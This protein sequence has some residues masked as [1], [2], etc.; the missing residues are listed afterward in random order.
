MEPTK[1]ELREE[2]RAIK[3]AGNKHR[4]YE[5]KRSLQVNP[6]EAAD[7]RENFGRH[8]L[9]L[10]ELRKTAGGPAE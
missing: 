9:G 10:R 6:D 7:V 2:K 8:R 3:R 4:R 1:R 5:L